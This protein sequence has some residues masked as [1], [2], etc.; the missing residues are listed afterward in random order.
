MSDSGSQ[1]TTITTG[2]PLD[3]NGEP[4]DGPALEIDPDGRAAE[5]F[6]DSPH[7]LAS[8][9]GMDMWSTILNYPEQSDSGKPAMLVWLGPE[10]TELP[11]HVHTNETE[12]LRAV[13]GDLTVVVEDEPTRLSPGEELT[14]QLEEP[15][16]FRNDTDDQVAFYAEVPWTKTIDT[17][18]MAFGM[19]HE[20]AFGTDGE[21]GEPDLLYGLLMFEYVRNGTRMTALPFSVQRILWAS[22]GR[23]AKAAGRSAV[24]DKYLQDEFW[25]KT[26]EQPSF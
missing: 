19:D 17:Q 8:S 25:K 13:N 2:R 10:A 7:A 26:V 24:N 3:E 11:A 23:V 12:V 15:H 4:T 6:S 14:I 22:V 18:F 9:P 1:R 21:Y 5:L 20:G 16:Y